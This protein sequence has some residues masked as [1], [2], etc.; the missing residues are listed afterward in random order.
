MKSGLSF[1]LIAFFFIAN[2][3]NAQRPDF[4]N[5]IASIIYTNCTPCHHDGGMAPFPLVSYDD[6]SLYSSWIADVVTEGIM[7]PWPPD[8]TYQHFVNERTLSAADIQA[9]VDWVNIGAPQGCSDTP[10]QPVYTGNSILGTPDLQLTIPT[11]TSKATGDDDHVCF[12]LPT[13]LTTNKMIRAIEVIPGN[14][15]IVHHAV[16]SLDTA[17]TF[18]TDTSSGACG[19]PADAIVIAGYAPGVSPVVF[20]N[21]SGVKM[22]VSLNVGTNVIVGLHYPQGSAGGTDYTSVN[23]FFY[24]DGETGIREVYAGSVL[25][26]WTFCVPPGSI[27]EVVDSLPADT[28]TIPWDFSVLSVTPHMHLLGKSFEV[29]ALDA[30]RDT[31]PFIKINDWDFDWQDFYFF[32]KIKKLPA[33]SK[34]FG[35]AVYDNTAANPHS[36]NVTVCAGSSTTDEMF[37]VSLYVLPYEPGDENINLDSLLAMPGNDSFADPPKRVPE[38]TIYP[39]PFTT[40]TVLEYELEEQSDVSLT[41]NNV[42]GQVVV[43]LVLGTEEPGF[44]CVHWDG[45]NAGGSPVAEGVYFYR[46]QIGETVKIGKAVYIR[47]D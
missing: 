46:L 43:Q 40:E 20:P 8:T 38:V 9:I 33:G 21:G 37:L 17:G 35:R 16:I 19:G 26:D 34:L 14:R 23:L 32:K 45:K 44:H 10:P 13:G 30:N 47:T 25:S 15:E 29:Y 36:Q 5:D 42:K 4:N 6:I 3:A 31:I 2:S 7:P 27:T 41:I 39:N 28:S 12:S 18:Q 24:P 1:F 11:Y 22:G